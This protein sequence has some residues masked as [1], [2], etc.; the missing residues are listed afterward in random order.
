V[1]VLTRKSGERIR[2]GD[3]IA[4]T[5]LQVKNREIRIAIDAP[6]CVPIRRH[7]PIETAAT[8]SRVRG[9]NHQPPPATHH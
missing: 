1:L 3:T 6:T 7:G 5:L 8:N 2:I 4:L 9:V